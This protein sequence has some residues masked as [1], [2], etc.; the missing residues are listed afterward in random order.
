[1]TRNAK[2]NTKRNTKR[3]AKPN[4]KRNTPR[5]KPPEI[6]LVVVVSDLH[7]GSE[8]ALCPPSFDQTE[9]LAMLRRYLYTAWTQY[10]A[11]VEE[12]CGGSP[13]IVVVNGDCV[14]G[15][16]HGARGLLIS[17]H[18]R[19]WRA[20]VELLRPLIEPSR[21]VYF[22]HGTECHTL[23]DEEDLAEEL[24]AVPDPETGLHAW[25]RLRLDMFGTR[26]MIRH[27]VGTTSRPWLT[28]NA[29][30]M[31]LAAERLNALNA[32]E[33]PTDVLVVGHRHLA[34]EV[35]TENGIAI[36][37]PSWQFPTRHVG[38]VVPD[39]RL[40]CGGSILDFRRTTVRGLPSRWHFESRPEPPK[41]VKP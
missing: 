5:A 19:Q 16:H 4:A 20:A 37:T 7:V 32:R 23:D 27:H 33:H 41:G 21:G 15:R 30:G 35:L 17:S 22:T 38:K 2:R 24:R 10:L 26:I 1:M 36:A 9:R 8:F 12:A 14:E 34:G 31:S 29:L 25:A 3:N 39:A 28:A 6:P 11:F 13:Y 40:V 18:V